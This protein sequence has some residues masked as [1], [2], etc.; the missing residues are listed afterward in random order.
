VKLPN[1]L[2]QTFISPLGKSDHDVVNMMV[3][4]YRRDVGNWSQNFWVRGALTGIVIQKTYDIQTK[5]RTLFYLLVKFLSYGTRAND[6]N[7]A[8]SQ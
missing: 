8:F 7:P 1:Q 5:L 4:N 6:E 3:D 2:I